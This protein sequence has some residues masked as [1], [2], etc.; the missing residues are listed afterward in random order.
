LGEL[1]VSKA[2]AAAAPERD[3]G[4]QVTVRIS[5]KIFNPFACLLKRVVAAEPAHAKQVAKFFPGGV[6]R[7]A[8]DRVHPPQRQRHQPGMRI[9]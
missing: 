2:V 9:S 4:G 1:E 7:Q 5:S 6:H 8:Q 3:S